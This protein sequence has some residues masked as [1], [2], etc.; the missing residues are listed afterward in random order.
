M[1][2]WRRSTDYPLKQCLYSLRARVEIIV[3]SLPFRLSEC[4]YCCSVLKDHQL[5]DSKKSDLVLED[6]GSHLK[7]WDW[8]FRIQTCRPSEI[9]FKI[10]NGQIQKPIVQLAAKGSNSGIH[11]AGLKTIL[12]CIRIPLHVHVRNIFLTMKTTVTE[13]IVTKNRNPSTVES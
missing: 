4:L 6:F 12:K 1:R 3:A 2:S 13:E 8:I 11:H 5:Q 10:S 9:V 7:V